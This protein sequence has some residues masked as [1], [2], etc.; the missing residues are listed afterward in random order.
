MSAKRMII[1]TAIFSAVIVF[2]TSIG[3]VIGVA[4]FKS[5]EYTLAQ[6]KKDIEEYGLDGLEPYLVE[7]A[8]KTWDSVEEISDNTILSSLFAFLEI[9]DY[10]SLIKTEIHEVEWTAGDFLKSSDKCSVSIGFN[11]KDKLVGKTTVTMSKID[12]SWYISHFTFPDIEK[13]DL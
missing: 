11:Y 4:I 9:K 5:P 7:D 3:M 2:G 1:V 12:G 8:K 13:I 10:I 6:I